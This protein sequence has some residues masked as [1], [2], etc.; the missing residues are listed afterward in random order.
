MIIKHG[1]LDPFCSD[2]KPIYDALY[3]VRHTPSVYKRLLWGFNNSNFELF[4][5]KLGGG[6]N[7]LNMINSTDNFNECEHNFMG[8]FMQLAKMCICNITAIV[9]NRGCIMKIRKQIR[10]RKRIH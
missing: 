1:A 2:H 3:S 4:R 7:Y 8:T 9:R 10:T 6:I 5:L